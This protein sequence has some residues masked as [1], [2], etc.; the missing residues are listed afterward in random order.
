MN[1]AVIN[2]KVEPKVK[3]Q[4]KVVA[5]KIGI[6]LSSLI[7][8]YLKQLIA[9]E[10]VTFRVPEEPT[11]WLLKQ[12]KE[13]HEDIKKGRVSPAF[14]NAKDAIR[15]LNNKNRKYEYQIQQKVQKASGKSR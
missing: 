6:S 3:R 11:P 8:A 12:L 10:S 5:E 4:A 1:T 2:I 15:W 14:N 13:S 9:T 7:H